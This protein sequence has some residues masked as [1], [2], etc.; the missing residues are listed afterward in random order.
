MPPDPIID[1]IVTS[2][3]AS[4]AVPEIDP[5]VT[6]YL[7]TTLLAY[8]AAQYRPKSCARRQLKVGLAPWQLRRAKAALAD[9]AQRPTLADMAR[10]CKVS[11]SHF[12]RSFK[13]AEGKS[14]SEW[15]AEYR[16]ARAVDML[17]ESPLPIAEI[18][19]HCGFSDQSHFTRSFTRFK[20]QPPATWRRSNRLG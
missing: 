1:G 7:V 4:A 11:P 2:L 13:V 18:A 8:L 3:Q 5:V 15:L 17:R 19:V 6:E 12:S 9:L 10:L 16:I 20:G 14:P